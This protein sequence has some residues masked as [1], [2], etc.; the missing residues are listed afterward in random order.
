MKLRAEQCSEPWLIFHDNFDQTS[1]TAIPIILLKK[2]LDTD[3]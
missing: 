3:P 2:L 1:L